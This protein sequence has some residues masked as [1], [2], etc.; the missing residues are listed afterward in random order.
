MYTTDSRFNTETMTG[1]MANGKVIKPPNVPEFLGVSPSNGT[2][3]GLSFD[4]LTSSNET[5]SNP[6]LD[7]LSIS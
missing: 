4:L 2:F 3:S 7:L 1:Y 5:L 6:M